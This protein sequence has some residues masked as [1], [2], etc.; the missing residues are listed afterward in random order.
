YLNDLGLVGSLPDFSAMDALQT[1]DFGNNSLAQEI[2][3]F[4]GTLPKLD[5]LNLEDNNF[6][7][8]IP[9]SLLRNSNLRLRVTGNPDLSINNNDTTICKN[10]TA[11]ASIS[12]NRITSALPV[13][14]LGSIIIQMLVM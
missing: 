14:I 7:G 12:E 5:I 4:L 8:D 10:N 1:I 2:P 6:S 13:I 11:S 3:E 9:C